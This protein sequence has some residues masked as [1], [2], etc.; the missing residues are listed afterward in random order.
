MFF[1]KAAILV[2]SAAAAF[3]DIKDKCTEN[4][5]PM[6]VRLAYYGDRGMSISWN[7]N[8]KLSK[9]TV[10]FDTSPNVHSSAS[11]DMSVTYPTSSTYNNHVTITGLQPDTRYYY[12]VQCDRTTYSFT[13]ARSVG[14][15]EEFKFAMVGDLGTMGPLGLSSTVGTGAA[16]P[17]A[18]GEQNSIDSLQELKG[19]YDFVWHGLSRPWR[20]SFIS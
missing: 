18:P 8:Q 16:N 1:L 2:A 3:P 12:M 13:T 10:Y 15:A 6:Q 11:S 7:T 9:P 17:L 14:N 4:T 20:L 5:E 19:S